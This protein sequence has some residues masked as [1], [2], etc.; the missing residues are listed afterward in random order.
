MD[1]HSHL[2]DSAASQPLPL[3]AHALHFYEPDLFPVQ[4][5]AAFLRTGL[6][7][8]EL[9]LLIA[10]PEHSRA[11]RDAL[12]RGNLDL[13]ALQRSDLLLCL[14]APSVLAALKSSGGT[15]RC[16]TDDLLNELI[17]KAV[18]LSPSGRVRVFG[19]LINLLALAGDYEAGLQLEAHWNRL[20]AIHPFRLYCAC[21]TAGFLH[22][23]SAPAV[24]ALCRLHDRLVPFVS[25]PAT[26]SWLA[27][28][29]LQSGAL[30]AE[31]QKR[32]AAE[33]A[34]HAV[35]LEYAR[36][37]SEH[38]DHLRKCLEESLR[39]ASFCRGTPMQNSH[40]SLDYMVERLLCDILEQC[41]AA[42]IARES[43]SPGGPES[44]KYTGEI[45][46]YG[47]LTSALCGLQQRAQARTLH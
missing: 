19:E 24:A 41:Q 27:P 3:P 45:L 5:I 29:L 37:F 20:L 28:L 11:V 34:L 17:S 42:C 31:M 43:A 13:E 40:A 30:Q 22:E 7:D 16:A 12:W 15:C 32:Q 44:Q 21:S 38:V 6:E 26:L 2:P 4:S 46:A 47:R 39:P 14:D 10:T 9:A 18:R 25:S 8:G 33:K 23:S 36:L 1:P 35:E